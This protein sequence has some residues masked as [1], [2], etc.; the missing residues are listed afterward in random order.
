MIPNPSYCLAFALLC[1][2]IALVA[3]L[4]ERRDYAANWH[5]DRDSKLRR[6]IVDENGM[7][8]MYVDG[9]QC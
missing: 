5:P 1:G 6:V 9:D 2:L 7:P 4:K 3:W 8:L